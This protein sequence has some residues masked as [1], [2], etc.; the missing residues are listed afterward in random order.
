MPEGAAGSPPF[1]GVKLQKLKMKVLT[2]FNYLFYKI[3]DK[4][5][6]NFLPLFHLKFYAVFC[7]RLHVR[8]P[9]NRLADDTP[10]HFFAPFYGGAIQSLDF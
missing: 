8:L 4:R 2:P 6:R 3:D 10:T 7:T 9:T 1:Y 5:G